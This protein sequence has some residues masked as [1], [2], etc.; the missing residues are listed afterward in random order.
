[1]Q[2]GTVPGGA[3]VDAGPAKPQAPWHPGKRATAPRNLKV[4]RLV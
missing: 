2:G 4:M 1:M 3:H